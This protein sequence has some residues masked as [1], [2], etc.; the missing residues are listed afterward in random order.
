[1]QRVQKPG[2]CSQECSAAP[3]HF[4]ARVE[5]SAFRSQKAAHKNVLQR[6]RPAGRAPA[7][8]RSFWRVCAKV[9]IFPRCHGTQSTE[10]EP[11]VL[12]SDA[13]QENVCP[14]LPEAPPVSQ[15][16]AAQPAAQASVQQP[17]PGPDKPCSIRTEFLKAIKGPGLKTVVRESALCAD[18]RQQPVL[19]QRLKAAITRADDLFRAEEDE[20]VDLIPAPAIAAAAQ[21]LPTAAYQVLVDG[22]RPRKRARARE[23][24]ASMTGD[25]SVF[26]KNKI[27]VYLYECRARQGP[28]RDAARRDE[29]ARRRQV[30]CGR[31]RLRPGL[32]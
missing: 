17:A 1:M 23:A 2:S 22:Q 14:N 21:A 24:A 13:D 25:Q 29:G 28:S 10:H 31:G 12:F 11:G 30:A 6:R 26:E 18:N 19:P 32:S 3:R 20:L 15:R 5:C 27:T 9:L 8:E 16:P 7:A 4:C